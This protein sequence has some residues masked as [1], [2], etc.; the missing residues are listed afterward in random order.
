MADT[1][2]AKSQSL[3]PSHESLQLR[4][5]CCER[6]RGACFDRSL[7]LQRALPAHARRLRL[8]PHITELIG[9]LCVRL[10][11]RWLV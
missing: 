3:R 8:R 6:A 9:L 7:S 10:K 11:E 2:H 1:R 5:R 4:T